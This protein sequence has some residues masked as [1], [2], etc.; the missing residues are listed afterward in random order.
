MR[1]YLREA[2]EQKGLTQLDMAEKIG[3]SYS[4]YRS[5]EHGTHSGNVKYWDRLEDFFGIPQ[6]TLRED[7]PSLPRLRPKI[8]R[9]RCPTCGQTLKTKKDRIEKVSETDSIQSK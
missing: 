6:R 9:E 5:M 3:V 8:E 4:F 1:K 2:R 7:F